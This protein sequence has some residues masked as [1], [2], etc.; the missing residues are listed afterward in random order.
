[1]QQFED[2]TK[3]DIQTLNEAV[4]N[5]R[6][7]THT[8]PN[9]AVLDATTA[10]YTTEEQQKL[11]G[12]SPETYATQDDLN[13]QILL[14][15]EAIAPLE[16]ASHNHTNKA[17]LDKITDVI[18]TA[19]QDFGPFEDWTRERI[20]TL[21]ELVNNFS[22]TAHTHENKAALDA[23]TQDMVDDLGGLQQFEDS[24]SSIIN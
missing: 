6:Q 4:D 16:H 3:H 23:I 12:I 9:A 24:E 1:M 18:V 13:E 22:N 7:K 11:A 8:H 14:V 17:V 20:H 2:S 21:F 5:L 19:V 15:R 10:P